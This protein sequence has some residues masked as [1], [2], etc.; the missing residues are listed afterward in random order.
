MKDKLFYSRIGKKG[1][2]LRWKR[3]HSKTPNPVKMTKEKASLNA[4]LCGDGNICIREDK[5]KTKH[6]EIK[7]FPDDE[8]MLK[9][10]L[11]CL[12]KVYNI[13]VKNIKKYR[14]MYYV[15]FNNKIVCKNLLKLGR[16][17]KYDWTIPS[18][19][20]RNF[21]KEWIKCFFDC[22]AHVNKKGFIQA[23]SVNFNGLKDVVSILSS[24][25]IPSCLNGPYTQKRGSSYFVLTINKKNSRNYLDKIGFNHSEKVKKLYSIVN[26]RPDGP[27][28]RRK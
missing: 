28:V 25:D 7:F 26:I 24:L 1:I 23:K 13:Q 12:S 11:F 2:R 14:K 10:I 21:K 9:N 22:E 5:N 8:V 17:G 16:Y 19:I 4:Y 27:M 3:I 15:R 6:Y 20:K 18:K